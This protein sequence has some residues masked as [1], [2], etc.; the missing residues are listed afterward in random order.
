LESGAVPV[1]ADNPIKDP[2]WP[3]D[4]PTIGNV[5]VVYSQHLGLWLMTYDGGRQSRE[6][7]GV[8][9]AYAGEPWGPWSAPQLIFNQKRDG[10][11]GSSFTTPASLQTRPATV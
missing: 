7:A 3:N 6:T 9:F 1:V 2:A 10:A 11:V 4:S 5:S 8:Y